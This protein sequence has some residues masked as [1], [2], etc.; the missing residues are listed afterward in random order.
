M[1]EKKETKTD[2]PDLKAALLETLRGLSEDERRELLSQSGA[3]PTTQGLT[4]EIFQTLAASFASVSQ[5]AVRETLRQ[6]RKENP[7]YPERSV[8]HPP[9]VFDDFG[10]ALPPKVKL[11]RETF[12]NGVRLGGELET[13][14]E[15]E[16]CNRFT[17]SRTA[18]EGLWTAEL[19]G[20]GSKKRLVITVPSKTLDERMTLPPFTHILR[21]LLEGPEAVN[22]E[23]MHRRIAELEAHV[24]T[25]SQR[26]AVA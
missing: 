11:T 24:K 8:F 17:D 16:L 7:S 14:D 9:G 23:T 18:C 1:A 26:S 22:P 20:V 6:E 25:L 5:G 3:V 21:E 4:P 19:E 12:F 13:A 10:K 15:I 2:N